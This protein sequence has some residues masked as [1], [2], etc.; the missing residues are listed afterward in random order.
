MKKRITLLIFIAVDILILLAVILI[1]FSST[2]DYYTVE[3]DLNGGVLLSG[4]LKQTV[5]FG[6]NAK[7]PIV[8]KDG[9]KFLEWSDDWTNITSDKVIEAIWDFDTTFGIQ[10]DVYGNGNYCLVNGS[11]ENISGDVYISAYYYDKRVLGIKDQAFINRSR[12]TSISLP[13]GMFSIGNESFKGCT[14]LST[15]IFP[16]T[17]VSIGNNGFDGCESITEIVL[18]DSLVSIGDN[19][20]SNCINLTKLTIGPNVK[21]ISTNSFMNLTSLQEIIVSDDNPNFMSIDGNLYTKDGKTLIKYASGKTDEI[22]NI[23]DSVEVIEQYAFD[24]IENLKTINISNSLHKINSNGFYMCDN[25]EYTE[26][27]GGFYFG[28]L[29]NPHLML[30]TIKDPEI[31]E[32]IVHDSTKIVYSYSLKNC[33]NLETVVLPSGLISIGDEAFYGCKNLKNI[34]LPSS[35]I[36]IG[37][38]AFY[39]CENIT[40]ILVPLWITEIKP[41]TFEGCINLKDVLL[42]KNIISIG[43]DAF[44]GCENIIELR[45]PSSLET[46]GTFSFYNCKLLSEIIVPSTVTSIGRAAFQGCSSLES[47]TLPFTGYSMDQNNNKFFGYIF[48]CIRPNFNSNYIP[49]SLIKVVITKETQLSNNAFNGCKYIEELYLPSSIKS[50]GTSAFKNCKGLKKVYFNGTVTDWCNI[51]FDNYD[52]LP[53]YYAEEI[54]FIN[55]E[56]EYQLVEEITIDNSITE[57]GE[58]QFY[59]FNT[60]KKVVIGNSITT[61]KGYTFA[62]CDVL[63]YVYFGENIQSIEST[64]F[65]NCPFLKKE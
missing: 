58:Y 11:F 2:K 33:L 54:Y 64:V 9:E 12:M 6:N 59:N 15:I 50:V 24:N 55:E 4:D 45:L 26:Y 5:K 1:T 53:Q 7:P 38:S 31:T 25:V 65:Q 52:S 17:L 46:I 44:Y 22:F 49:S 28:S 43:D 32:L 13:S 61:L 20:F 35:L 3:F 34:S 19:A 47:I 60:L 18:P 62:E 63:E 8:S 21:D 57:L 23:P 14:S 16:D 51:K 41:S 56:K 42:S 36:S 37:S 10:F 39:G 27:N 40:S 30:Y 29:D 48:G